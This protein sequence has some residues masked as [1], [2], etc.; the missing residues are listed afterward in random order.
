M[1][2]PDIL[3]IAPAGLFAGLFFGG[4]LCM[5]GWL[6]DLLGPRFSYVFEGLAVLLVTNALLGG[7]ND[8][9]TAAGA[10][11]VAAALCSLLGLWATLSAARNPGPSPR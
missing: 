2:V 8:L 9:Y 3:I 10:K 7:G 11:A 1:D 5:T 6:R 4:V